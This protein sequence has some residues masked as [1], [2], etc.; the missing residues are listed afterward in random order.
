[1]NDSTR[2]TIGCLV[3]AALIAPAG[4]IADSVFTIEDPEVDFEV[5]DLGPFD[6]I[7]DAG[8]FGTYN[9]VVLGSEGEAREMAEFDISAFS[10]PGGEII[11]GATFEVRISSILVSGLGVPSGDTPDVLAAFGYVGNGVQ[12]Q[13]DF[14]AGDANLLGTVDTSDPFVGQIVSYDVT[15]FVTD[16]VDAGETWVGLTIAAQEFGGLAILENGEYPKL[17]IETAEAPADCEGDANG[18]GTVDPLD[19]GFV[20]AR[21]GCPVGTGD[22]SCDAAD[23]NGDGAVDPLDSGF[24]LAR[25]GDCP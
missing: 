22:P 20:L 14:Q 12:E 21:F 18:D 17:T 7:G 5:L 23:Q 25:F 24:V 15:S 9:T 13:S 16:L 11:T 3:L 2:R 19:S 8:P 1:M 10:V 4:V 6:G